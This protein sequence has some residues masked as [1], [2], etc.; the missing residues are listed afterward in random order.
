LV[1]TRSIK[2]FTT[3]KATNLTVTKA[4][5][6]FFIAQDT[7]KKADGTE[8]KQNYK[9]WSNTVVQIGQTVNI[10][11]SASANVNEFNDQATGKPVVYA[12]PVVVQAQPVGGA[13]QYWR[14]A[15]CDAL[16]RS[17]GGAESSPEG[18]GYQ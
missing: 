1:L 7:F 3:T 4:F 2:S 11:G 10:I 12:Q 16:G 8:G 5:P 6:K 9:V 14:C 18:V 15:E 13:D 17:H